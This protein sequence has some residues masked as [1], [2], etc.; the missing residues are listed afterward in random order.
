MNKHTKKF[1]IIYSGKGKNVNGEISIDTEDG[2]I[3]LAE[4]NGDKF[5]IRLEDG[6]LEMDGGQGDFS[7]RL[8]DGDADIRDAKFASFEAD[9]EDGTIIVETEIKDGGL[10]D[11]RS[12]DANVEFVVLSG[13][14]DFTLTK[15]DGSVRA[16]SDFELKRETD[17]REEYTLK[18]GTADVE[19]RTSDGRIRLVKK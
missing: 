6:D 5:D 8:D 11:I 2:D 16:G 12:D 7:L 4:C 19:I 13:G 3:E 10:Y 14:G 9:V 17:Y 1:I 15:D 18:G